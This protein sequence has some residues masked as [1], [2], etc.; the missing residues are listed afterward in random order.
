MPLKNGKN[1]RCLP[2]PN[3]QGEVN[4]VLLQKVFSG[5]IKAVTMNAIVIIHAIYKRCDLSLTKPKRNA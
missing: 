3:V 1:D 5:Y 4:D 2:I